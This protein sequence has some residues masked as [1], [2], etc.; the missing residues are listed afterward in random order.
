MKRAWAAASAAAW[1]GF[2]AAATAAPTSA[3]TSLPAGIEGLSAAIRDIAS[4]ATPEAAMSAYARGCNINRQDRALQDAY[5]RKMLK[6]GRPE[7]AWFAAQ[8]LA[9]MD[10]AYG[11]PQGV[12]AYV[13]A[14]RDNLKEAFSPGVRAA[15]LDPNNVPTVQNAAQLLA[16]YEHTD[17]KPA[18]AQSVKDA[19]KKLR[20]GAGGKAFADAY[21]QACDVYKSPEQRKKDLEQK[22]S[23]VRAEIQQLNQKVN[24]AA[25]T[26]RSGEQSYAR[27]LDELRRLQRELAQAELD[28]RTARNNQ[29]R[30]SAE[31]RR[32]TAAN[33]I[34]KCQQ[35]T[36]S[37]TDEAAKAQRSLADLKKKLTDKRAE[38]SKA[39][40]GA[41]GALDAAEDKLRWRVPAVD[42][43][44]VA[45]ADAPKAPSRSAGAATAATGP[46]LGPDA[47]LERRLAEAKAADKLGLA[48]MYLDG[49]MTDA[50]RRTLREIVSKY[51][52]TAAAR[53]AAELLKGL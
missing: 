24:S 35:D 44:L 39:Q 37:L 8:V 34:R 26:L 4:A 21:K 7:A 16:W 28:M 27:D 11:L 20:G 41:R 42:G 29:A 22:A 9:P 18:I 38:L 31:R 2:C 53:E 45:D 3:R 52:G 15:V 19:M 36:A 1:L 43:I 12:I 33:D 5:M 32:T 51:P 49:K 25:Q 10:L 13:C 17:A 50:A 6:L 14:K 40:A 48:K 47:P 23:A 30:R 46:Q